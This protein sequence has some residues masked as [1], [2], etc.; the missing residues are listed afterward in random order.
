[1]ITIHSAYRPAME[2]T[3]R[4]SNVTYKV[5]VPNVNYLSY[6]FDEDKYDMFR[7]GMEFAVQCEFLNIQNEQYPIIRQMQEDGNS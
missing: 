2:T 3:L 7:L 4:E 5:T 6:E 1:M